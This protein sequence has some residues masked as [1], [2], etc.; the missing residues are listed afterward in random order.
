[1]SRWNFKKIQFK[2]VNLEEM[3]D[4]T[5]LLNLYFT[6]ILTLFMGAIIIFFQHNNIFLKLSFD[7]SSWFLLWGIGFALLFLSVDLILSRFVPEEVSDDGGMNVKL[8]GTRALWHILLISLVVSFCEELLF[9]GAIQHAFGPYWTSI[10]FAAI[11][12][13]YLKHWLM[14]GL[15]FSVSY[16]LGWIYEQTGTLWTPILAHFLI[17]FVM[18]CIIRYRREA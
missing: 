17:D 10:L 4:R 15:V 5:L 13:R 2:K 12:I 3:D 6:Q 18:G 1:M 9:R 8:F 11:H 7:Q 14:T 16:G